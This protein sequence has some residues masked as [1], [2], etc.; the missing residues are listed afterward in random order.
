MPGSGH[1]HLTDFNVAVEVEDNHLPSSMSGT[2]PYMA[3]EIFDCGLDLR[4]GYSYGVDWWSLGVVAYEMF[5]GYRPFDIHSYT[6]IHNVRI[7]F[8]LGV[9]YPMSFSDSI[10][11]L[12]AKLLCLNPD[13]RASSVQ[14]LKKIKCL[15]RF[16]M[17]M[18]LQ[19]KYKPP[20]CPPND[21]L[22]CDPTFELEEM[23]VETK[24]LHKK[25]KR[26]AKQR[27]I[28]EIQGQLIP[29]DSEANFPDHSY[30]HPSTLLIP[31]F[32]TYNRCQELEKKEKERKE[33][34]WER[35]LQLAMDLA[36]PHHTFQIPTCKSCPKLLDKCFPETESP[37]KLRK[38]TSYDSCCSGTNADAKTSERSELRATPTT[39]TGGR[40][41]AVATAGKMS[42]AS[43]VNYVETDLQP[44]DIRNTLQ[45]IEFIDRTPSPSERSSE[46]T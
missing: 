42:S 8:H 16:D 22:N 40:K 5:R 12:L 29:F 4:I 46:G 17:D 36:D 19:K 15:R 18:V 27:S 20:F 14:D 44:D 21:H 35:E 39:S 38:M 34:E 32:K 45:N 24:P 6:S 10:V 37:Q 31:E 33:M 13:F 26:L 25:K 41:L 3:P 43:A 7:L 2:K 30:P 23:I 9:E 28:R 1:A 11:D